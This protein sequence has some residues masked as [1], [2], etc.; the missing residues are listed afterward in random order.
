MS[1]ERRSQRLAL[2][3]LALLCLSCRAADQPPAV[4]EGSAASS[5]TVSMNNDYAK[6]LDLE[7]QEDFEQ[8]SRGLVAAAPS[9]PVKDDQ[10]QVVWDPSEY[11]FIQGDA[12]S[13]VNPSLWR[14]SRLNMNRGLYRVT[15]GIHQLRGFD[16]AN[17]TL[18]DGDEGWIV[19]DPLTNTDTARQALAFARE[20]L[21]EKRVS[22]VIFTHSHVDH[23]GGAL[24]VISVN[25]IEDNDVP[26]VAPAGFIEQATSENVVAGPAMLRRA[27]FMYG[28]GLPRSPTGHVNTGLGIQPV[29]AKTS[30]L[31]PN[32]IIEESMQ[33]VVL[34]GVRFR[35][36]NTPESEAPAELVFYL[37][38]HRAFCGAE[39]LSHT[40]HNLYT[41]RGTKVRDAF[42]WSDYIDDSITA[43]PEA[44]IY[45][46]SHHWPIWGRDRIVTFLEKQRDMYRFINDQTL[47]W[48]N[49]GLTPKE[50]AE[51]IEMPESL[52]TEFYNRD[53]YGTLR[54][55][56]KAVYQRYFGWYTGN[57]ADLNPHPPVEAAKRYVEYMGGSEAVIQKA[58]ASFD[59]GDYRWVAEV[60]NHVVFSEPQNQSAKELLAQAYEQMGYQAE[61]G[62]WRDVYL[63]GAHELLRGDSGEALDLRD[64]LPLLEQTPVIQF[65]KAMSVRL[66]AEEAHGKEMTINFV[67]PDLDES[68]VVHLKNSVLHFRESEPS[69]E[70]NATLEVT[71]PMFLKMVIGD[72]SLKDLLLSKELKLKGSR[73]DVIR[74]FRLLDKPDA[75]FP[76]VTP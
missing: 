53:Y 32:K 63:T 50:I 16:L 30:I 31:V 56:S 8:A 70:A 14:Q 73:V 61:S 38:E 65:L 71:H 25:E 57:P 29:A 47:R 35:F 20:H 6:V 46:G 74:F 4:P 66:K 28:I 2:L 36:M 18:I 34:D 19:V 13:T 39:I 49:A 45:F 1:T 68:Y 55:N 75:R 44:D 12:P 76:I 60:L 52:A 37:P 33:D 58:R 21:G 72:V 40:M 27:E 42:K 22:A 62:P 23:F 48:A 11:D 59:E 69:A 43:F 51:R 3:T 26:V 64:A 7:N 54:H 24:G 17:M 41:L 9:V 15:E 67:F 10:G 5:F